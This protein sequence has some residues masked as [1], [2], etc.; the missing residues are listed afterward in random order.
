MNNR[1]YYAHKGKAVGP[2]SLGELNSILQGIPSWRETLVWRE[3]DDQW[4]KAG[5]ISDLAE[6]RA[7]PPPIPK[8]QIQESAAI[9]RGVHNAT[10]RKTTLWPIALYFLAALTFSF[11]VEMSK[12]FAKIVDEFSARGGA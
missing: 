6:F 7:A 4:Q 9:P 2:L 8:D 10:S 3:G 5:S 12:P 1:W 11:Y